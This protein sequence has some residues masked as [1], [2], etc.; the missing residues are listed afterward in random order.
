[1][2]R[3]RELEGTEVLLTVRGVVRKCVAVTGPTSDEGELWVTLTGPSMAALVDI[4]P[5]PPRIVAG[6][7]YVDDDGNH[8]QGAQPSDMAGCVFKLDGHS[9][10][11]YGMGRPLP[12]GLHP[13]KVVPE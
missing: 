4:Q 2:T 8:Y 5:A 1:V 11:A 7:L 13:V 3:A 10:E 12:A 6:Q 9:Y